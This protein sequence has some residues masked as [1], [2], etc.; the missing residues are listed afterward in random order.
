M[1]FIAEGTYT[2]LENIQET[3]WKCMCIHTYLEIHQITCAIS[4]PKSSQLHFDQCE[5]F[6]PKHKYL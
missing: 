1:E 2:V 4:F 3:S 5:L 6:T